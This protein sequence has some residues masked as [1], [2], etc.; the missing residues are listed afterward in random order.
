MLTKYYRHFARSLATF[1]VLTLGTAHCYGTLEARPAYADNNIVTYDSEGAY[2][3]ESYPSYSYD[4]RTTYLV[5]DRWYFHNSNGWGYY[6]QEPAG[7][8]SYRSNY[9][10]QH[11]QNIRPAYGAPP[12]NRGHY[13]APRVEQPRPAENRPPPGRAPEQR[14]EE[15][16]RH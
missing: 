15:P 4:G 2:E 12:A 7:L 8:A 10:A 3:Y 9:Y 16:V 11:G 13:V 6:R 5:G 14:R 1:S